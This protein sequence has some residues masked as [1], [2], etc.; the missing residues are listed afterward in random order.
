MEAYLI[1]SPCD[2]TETPEISQYITLAPSKSV[3]EELRDTKILASQL[4]TDTANILDSIARIEHQ[5]SEQL[6]S[7]NGKL[8]V[9]ANKDVEELCVI[10]KIETPVKLTD[11]LQDMNSYLV[12]NQL[13]ISDTFEITLDSTLCRGFGISDEETK[14]PYIKVLGKIPQMFSYI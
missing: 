8:M 3:Y 6:W 11:F 14:I 7:P 13:L 4:C 12:E 5:I 1:S 9:P 10:M 2:S